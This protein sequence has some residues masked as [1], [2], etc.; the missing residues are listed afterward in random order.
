MRLQHHPSIALWAG[1]N[2][3]EVAL[4]GDWYD[5]SPLFNKYKADYIKLYVDTIKPIVEDLDPERRYLVSSPSNGRK[6]EEDGYI[7]VNPYDPHYGD[8]HYY[9]YFADNWSMSTYPKTRFASEYGFQSL[10]SLKTMRT[11]TKSPED[12]KLHSKY[13]EHRQHSP[14]GYSYIEEQLT[15]HLK[16]DIDD[17]KYFEKF[18]FYSQVKNLIYI[19]YIFLLLYAEAMKGHS[20]EKVGHV[21]VN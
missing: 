7:A 15:G 1:N 14:N 3:N 12:F 4:R 13:S 9:N 21:G 18:V 20:Q 8:T 17:P 16:L 19:K 10:P 6:S 11:A 5:T 2:E